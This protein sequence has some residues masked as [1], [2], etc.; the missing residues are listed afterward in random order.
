MPSSA[1]SKGETSARWWSSWLEPTHL[2]ARSRLASLAFT[3]QPLQRDGWSKQVAVKL[4]GGSTELTKEI[5][6]FIALFAVLLVL[7]LLGFFAFHVAG[8]LIHLLLIVAVI[9]LVVHFF[10]G[11][12]AA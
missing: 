11:R 4:D 7:W 1:C 3:L 8:G 2:A 12:S 10:R 5:S 6:M 9:S